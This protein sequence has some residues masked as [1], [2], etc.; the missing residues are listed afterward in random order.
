[1]FWALSPKLPDGVIL[2]S[3]S[4]SAANWWARDLKMRSGMMASISG[5]LATMGCGV[6][7]AI[8]AKF[9]FPNRPVMALVGDGAMQMGGNSGLLTIAK[10]WKSW[11]DP[12][13]V[14]L[15]LNN[16]D[17]NQVTWEMRALSGD[18]RY[19][20]SQDLPDFP[21]A[22]YAELIGL[23]GIFVDRPDQVPAAW[24]Q[25][26]SADRP[27]VVEAYV[28]PEVPP[29]PPHITLQQA[30]A[31]TSSILKGDARSASMIQRALHN[32]FPGIASKDPGASKVGR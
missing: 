17:L 32:M 12:R 6:P 15:V 10:Y 5:N 1:V 9:A 8:A 11:G 27:C 30:K 22:R 3:D 13:L 20:A 16:R 14:V 7:Y 21:Y 2:T 29:L 19:A 28:D 23:K 31:F 26:L 25:A 18:P 24:D 4:G